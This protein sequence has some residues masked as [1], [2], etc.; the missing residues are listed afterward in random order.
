MS[1]LD[2]KNH[3]AIVIEKGRK[4]RTVVFTAFTAA[5]LQQWLTGRA[6]V[7]HVFFNLRTNEPLTRSGLEQLMKRLKKKAGVKGRTNPHA[8]R[9]AFAREYLRNGGDLATLSRLMGHSE[10]GTTAAHYA[11]YSQNELANI[12]EALSPMNQIQEALE[13]GQ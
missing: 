2:M 13:S 5:L 6:D 11:L 4:A 9:H 3:R 12:H 7:P 10:V 8:F 1:N